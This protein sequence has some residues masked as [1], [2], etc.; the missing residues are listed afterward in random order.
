MDGCQNGMPDV[1]A[2][3]TFAVIFTTFILTRKEYG[4]K[5]IKMR[6]EGVQHLK[7]NILSKN[8]QRHL[9]KHGKGN[10]TK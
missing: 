8:Q 1:Q 9:Q 6:R 4:I 3:T 10:L 2:C 5:F 7:L